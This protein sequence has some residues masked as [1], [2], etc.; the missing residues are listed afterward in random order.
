M[1]SFSLES[2]PRRDHR[3]SLT[4][5]YMLP[6]D[7]FNFNVFNLVNQYYYRPCFWLRV[8][9]SGASTIVHRRFAVSK[10]DKNCYY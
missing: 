4:Y 8:Q 1:L 2:K 5:R 6:N 10:I 3:F 9:S 7:G